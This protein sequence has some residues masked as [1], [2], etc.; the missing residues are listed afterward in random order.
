M[1]YLEACT[2]ECPFHIIRRFACLNPTDVDSLGRHHD[3]LHV[4]L[5]QILIP[6]PWS[7]SLK[8][9]IHFQQLPPVLLE[10]LSAEV[11]GHIIRWQVCLIRHPHPIKSA[12]GH[13]QGF[14]LE[15][16]P[17]KVVPDRNIYYYSSFGLKI[18]LAMAANVAVENSTRAHVVFLRR[19]LI[20][21]TS[22]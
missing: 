8:R 17:I 6:E 11:F 18:Y 20:L 5:L 3:L 13:H 19:I 1:C 9:N 4:C 21:S 14:P 12:E 2:L 7:K 15:S 16:C 22:P 10:L